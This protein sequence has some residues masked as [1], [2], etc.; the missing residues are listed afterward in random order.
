MFT[1][2]KS[3]LLF[4]LYIFRNPLPFFWGGVNI[5]LFFSAFFLTSGLD[6]V[7][8]CGDCGPAG[9]RRRRRGVV[10]P[11]EED[12]HRERG[13]AVW[14]GGRGNT[15]SWIASRFSMWNTAGS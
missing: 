2:L 15:K 4:L 7:D 12:V 3:N 9:G 5:I 14:S 11:V 8:A 6:D 13:R 10:H 1:H